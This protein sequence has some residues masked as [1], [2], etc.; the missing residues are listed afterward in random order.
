MKKSNYYE[1]LIWSFVI[2]IMLTMAIPSK[3]Q[4]AAPYFCCDSITYN[5]DPSQG[6]NISLDTTGIIHNPDSIEVWWAVCTNG[7]CYSGDG[8]YDYFPQVMTTDTVHVCY[9][10]YLYESNTVEVCTHCDYLIF[11]GTSW[12]LFNMGNPT[13]INELTFNK[14]NDN[15]IYDLLGRELTKIP[16]G[17]LYIRNQKLYITR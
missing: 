9:D 15:K 6:F 17:K 3:A 13:S 11:N 16:V 4:Q 5:I 2:A 7:M 8:M 10:A 12:I 1:V 14:V